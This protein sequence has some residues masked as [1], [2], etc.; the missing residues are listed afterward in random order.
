MHATTP[1]FAH[2]L[3]IHESLGMRSTYRV[4]EALDDVVVVEAAD[5]PGL[6]PGFLMRIT[7]QAAD[8]MRVVSESLAPARPVAAPS[9]ELVAA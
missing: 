6:A 8:A 3:L 7:R 1:L 5:V 9:G 2:T 4:L